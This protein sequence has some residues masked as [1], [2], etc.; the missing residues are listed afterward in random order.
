MDEVRGIR[1]G[2]T[3]PW[4]DN[5]SYFNN[6]AFANEDPIMQE[7]LFKGLQAQRGIPYASLQAEAQRNRLGGLGKAQIGLGY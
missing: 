6:V 1:T 5:P 2:V 7:L 3:F 4:Q